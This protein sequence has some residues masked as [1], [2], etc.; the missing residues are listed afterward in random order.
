MAMDIAVIWVSGE[1]NYFYKWDWT[2]QISLILLKNFRFWRR[3]N[4][5]RECAPASAQPILR[6]PAP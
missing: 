6:A 5:P 1:A 3:A 4:G 2:T